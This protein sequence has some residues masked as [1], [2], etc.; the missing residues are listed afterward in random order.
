MGAE[1]IFAD[2]G[3]FCYNAVMAQVTIRNLDE[4]TLTVLRRRAVAR[5][6]TLAAELR[7]ICDAAA[8]ENPPRAEKP[9]MSGKEALAKME[10]VWARWDL[11]PRVAGCSSEVVREGREERKA[12]LVPDD[13][14]KAE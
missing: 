7:G 5:G 1:K 14:A 6:R 9:A 4:G 10:R 3:D 12:R 8:K 13:R 11:E 2:E